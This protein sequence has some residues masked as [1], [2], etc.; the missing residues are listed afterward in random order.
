MGEGRPFPL[1]GIPHS[2]AQG[3]EFLQGLGGDPAA[4]SMGVRAF[5]SAM[6]RTGLQIEEKL[7]LEWR[8]IDLVGRTVPLHRVLTQLIGN[9]PPR[10]GPRD[11]VLN[12]SH[13]TSIRNIRDGMEAAG[14]DDESAGMGVQKA[15][16][17]SLR[18]SA[19][20]HWL[21]TS[22]VPLNVV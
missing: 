17:H 14:L 6:W 16:A 9:W 12:L 5:S 3:Q 7:S 4:G 11:R 8:D 2:L 18:H 22:R 21:T 1:D 10:H 19:A 20:R 13:R 15:G